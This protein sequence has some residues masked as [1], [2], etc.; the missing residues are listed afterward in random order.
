M[1]ARPFMASGSAQTTP[2]D[3]WEPCRNS[4]AVDHMIYINDYGV[5]AEILTPS[6]LHT[7]PSGRHLLGCANHNYYGNSH[8][9]PPREFRRRGDRDF[10]SPLE[11]SEYARGAHERV[12][13]STVSPS[14]DDRNETASQ[15][16]PARS[17]EQAAARQLAQLTPAT[18]CG[19]PRSSCSRS[20]LISKYRPDNRS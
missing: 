3:H 9:N 7:Q 18:H 1:Y 16:S 12:S 11:T 13:C 6:R 8:G 5:H 4:R 20:S 15:T 2:R 10:L 19:N 14:P 17:P